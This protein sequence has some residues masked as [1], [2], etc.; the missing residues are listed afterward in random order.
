MPKK[1]MIMRNQVLV[2]FVSYVTKSP[3]ERDE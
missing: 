3:C 2:R 1:F